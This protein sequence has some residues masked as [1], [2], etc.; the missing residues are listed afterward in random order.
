MINLSINPHLLVYIL[1]IIYLIPCMVCAEA[2]DSKGRSGYL[3]F[4]FA[5]IATP[6]IGFLAVIAFPCKIE[7][8]NYKKNL[9]KQEELELEE[10]EL[11]QE[12]FRM[13]DEDYKKDKGVK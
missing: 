3:F 8:C 13:D 2:A 6:L 10:I 12:E 7:T 9:K 11:E 5:I 4:F 1:A